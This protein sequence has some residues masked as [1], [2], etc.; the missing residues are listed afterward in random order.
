MIIN[1]PF[2]ILTVTTLITS[3]LIAVS[4]TNWIILWTSIEINLLRF[5]PIIL[6]TIKNQETEAAI[7]Y[8]LAQSFGSSILLIRRI[9]IWRIFSIRDKLLIYILMFSIILKLGIVPCHI[10]YPSVIISISWYSC[11]ILSTW[12]KLAPLTIISFILVQKTRNILLFVAA[13][14]S[15]IGGIMGIN[16]THLRVILAYSSI[17]HMGWIV[18]ILAINKPFI[19]ITYL[20]IYSVVAFP[21]FIVFAFNN[22][23]TI[24]ARISDS[25]YAPLPHIFIAIRLLNLG[26]IPPLGGFAAKWLVLSELIVVNSLV[27]YFLI[28]GSLIAL[29]FYLNIGLSLLLTNI[30]KKNEECIFT[31]PKTGFLVAQWNVILSLYRTWLVIPRLL[32]FII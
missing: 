22:L 15:I 21:I 20:L 17:N 12:Q 25:I 26:G 2:S 23:S 19:T 29:Y 16:Q 3:T 1:T 8:F 28:L 4:R 13:L 9:S 11:A 5:I 30:S 14:N 31:D 18:R 6:F 10:W 32:I 24:S 27:C 7:K